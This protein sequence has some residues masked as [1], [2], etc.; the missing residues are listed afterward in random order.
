M[1]GDLVSVLKERMVLLDGAMGTM[2]QERG[3]QPGQCPELF[4]VENP[5][6]FCARSIVSIHRGWC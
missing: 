6:P 4:G 1:P 2:L 3:M 5:A